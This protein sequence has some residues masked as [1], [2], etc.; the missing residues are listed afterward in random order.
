MLLHESNKASNTTTKYSFV[1]S[2]E[3]FR[4]CVLCTIGIKYEHVGMMIPVRL[5]FLMYYISNHWKTFYI[6]YWLYVLRSQMNM[7]VL[8]IYIY[9]YVY[10]TC[11]NGLENPYI[12]HI[13]EENDYNS[14]CEQFLVITTVLKTDLLSGTWLCTLWMIS[15]IWDVSCCSLVALHNASE[16]FTFS[17]HSEGT[18]VTFVR[19]LNSSCQSMWRHNSQ[20]SFC[21]NHL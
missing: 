17:V 14:I 16:E 19:N 18:G 9:I 11:F 7:Y 2:D 12:N 20:A 4:H 13:L 3:T 10:I 21:R 5:S 6:L 1:S 15:V 8:I